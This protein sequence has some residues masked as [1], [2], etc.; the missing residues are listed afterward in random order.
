MTTTPE[1][2]VSGQ[3]GSPSI[4]LVMPLLNAMPYL[5]DALTSIRKQQACQLEVIAVDAGSTDGTREELEAFDGLRIIEAPGSTQTEALNLGFSLATGDLL[6]WLNGDDYLADGALNWVASWF[7]KRPEAKLLYGDAMAI[8]AGGR[9]FGLRS[10]VREGQYQQLLH[11]DFIVQPSAFWTRDVYESIG[12]LDEELQYTFDYDFFLAVAR[13]W[14]LNYEPV[15]FSFER[16]RGG[17]K[18]TQGGSQR[19]DELLVVMGKHDRTSV[20]M[21]F[22]P[23]VSAVHA[24]SALRMFRTD[25]KRQALKRLRSEL[26][27]G[28]PL[29]FTLIHLAAGLAGGPRG[30][31]KA[32]LIS[33]WLRTRYRRRKPVWPQ[34]ATESRK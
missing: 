10:N 8:N 30:T 31:A 14:P 6:G 27:E 21:A 1:P 26:V 24:S 17:S 4:T 34:I 15:V 11:G 9:P 28:R 3:V 18:T 22:K 12:S 25:D 7:S 13:Q 2:D 29:I 33:N 23:E 32:R 19:A 16:L 5:P 20:P